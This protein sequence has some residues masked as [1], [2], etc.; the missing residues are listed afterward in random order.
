MKNITNQLSSK[1]NMKIIIL[2]ASATDISEAKK[3]IGK[4]TTESILFQV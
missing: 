1:E 2:Q 4:W 3:T